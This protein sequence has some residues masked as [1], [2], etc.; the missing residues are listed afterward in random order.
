MSSK[1]CEWRFTRVIFG[2][3]PS[4]FLLNVALQRHIESYGEK[5]PEFVR[6]VVR[7][8]WMILWVEVVM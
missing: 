4:P 2:A 1:V 5:D 8:L 6:L 7:S 3:G